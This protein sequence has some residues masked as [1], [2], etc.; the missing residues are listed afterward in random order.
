MARPT[1]DT[2]QMLAA[3][4]LLKELRSSG[5]PPPSTYADGVKLFREGRAAFAIDGDWSLEG[6]RQYTDTLDLGIAPMP[7]VSSSG[8]A[9]AAPLGGIY[10]MYGASLEGVQLERARALG[11]ALAQP[12]AQVRLGRDLGL[13]PALRA[14]LADPAL[15]DTPALM[16]ARIDGA[17]GLPPTPALRCAWNAIGTLLP[18]V[19]LGEVE[20]QDAGRLMQE[21]AVNCLA[22]PVAVTVEQDGRTATRCAVGARYT[23]PLRRTTMNGDEWRRVAL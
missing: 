13:L 20:P 12:A 18:P 8:R 1:L 17:L 21:R 11:A 9:A 14:A 22:A 3:L 5:P 16:S 19:L 23:V 6:Y 2:P 15:H 7:Q 4:N 10:L